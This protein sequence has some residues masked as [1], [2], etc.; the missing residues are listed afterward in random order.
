MV[1]PPSFTQPTLT[2]TPLTPSPLAMPLVQQGESNIGKPYELNLVTKTPVPIGQ[3][4]TLQLQIYDPITGQPPTGLNIVHEKPAHLFIVNQDLSDFQH[5]HP[6]ILAPGLLEIPVQFKAPGN[7]KLFAQFTTP[8][9][10]EQTLNKPFS[11]GPANQPLKPLIPDAHLPKWVD[12]YEFR[13]SGLPTRA[14]PMSMFHVSVSKNGIPV[15]TIEPY[16]GAG[17]HGVILSSDSQSFIHTH[18]M[19]EAINGLYQSPV[20]F[21]TTIEQPGTY[22][23]WM[24][25]K[26]DGQV[27]TVDWTFRV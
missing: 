16:L 8:D 6:N 17:A 9:K 13:I 12:G 10:G 23:M 22:K 15:K 3:P 20:M 1:I 26:M 18:P 5:V 4:T 14:N 25:T 24:Q 19:A 21:H 27:H 11:I 7:Y 2:P